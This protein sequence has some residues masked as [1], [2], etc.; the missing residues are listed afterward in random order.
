MEFE[1]FGDTELL[2]HEKVNAD[3]LGRGNEVPARRRRTGQAGA[4]H[5][6]YVVAGDAGQRIGVPEPGR[7]ASRSE[8]RRV[9]KECR[10]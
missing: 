4:L 2:G 6:E 9:G 7:R 1:T 5:P 10:L 3:S 8:E